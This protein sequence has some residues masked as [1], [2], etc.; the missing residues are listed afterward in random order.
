GGWAGGGG[1]GRG[2]WE[3]RVPPGSGRALGDHSPVVRLPRPAGRTIKC[4]PRP[5]TRLV[6]RHEVVE[7]GDADSGGGED[8]Q[9]APRLL[10]GG[11]IDPGDV[12]MSDRRA[13]ECD[14][15]EPIDADVANEA[16]PAH[17]QRRV[18]DSG[19]TRAKDGPRHARIVM[20]EA[21]PV[22]VARLA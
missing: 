18:L 15:R 22:C 12:A 8:G 19:D 2:G 5:R 4:T 13:D 7:G 17:Q 3:V 14:P 11:D 9:H 16:A 20:I 21:E 10:S 6:Q 1:R